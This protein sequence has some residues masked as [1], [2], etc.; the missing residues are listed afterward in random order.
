MIDFHNY[1]KEKD[2]LSEEAV[3]FVERD[4]KV[5]NAVL[6]LHIE[7]TTSPKITSLTIPNENSNNEAYTDINVI[8]YYTDIF[9]ELKSKNIISEYTIK[10]YQEEKPNQTFYYIDIEVR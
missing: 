6:R 8:K 4:L 1:E 10:P 7:S 3:K 9:E 2:N 5:C